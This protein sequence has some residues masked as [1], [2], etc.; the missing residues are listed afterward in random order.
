MNIA[1]V[2]HSAP[3]P[4]RK[5]GWSILALGL[6][7]GCGWYVH[8]FYGAEIAAWLRL[9][10]IGILVYACLVLLI[11]LGWIIFELIGGMRLQ[12]EQLRRQQE[13]TQAAQLERY[14]VEIEVSQAQVELV[15]AEREAH[16]TVVVADHD[17]AVFV[18]DAD[19]HA[20]WKPLHLIPSFRIN[21]VEATPSPLELG[22]WQ[23]WLPQRGSLPHPTDPLL[24]PAATW[25]ERIPLAELM[26]EPPS[27][28]RLLLGV[29]LDRSGQRQVV[30]GDMRQLIHVA[31]GGSSGWGKSML[32]RVLTYQLLLALEQPE[33]VLIDLEPNALAPFAHTPRLRFPLA[34]TETM[35]R[36]VLAALKEEML[37][38]IDLFARYE[39]DDLEEYNRVAAEPLKPI[40]CI[41]D[42]VNDL[43]EIEA[44]EN[45]AQIL[46]RRGRKAGI[47][48]IL[49]AQEWKVTAIDARIRRQ[50]STKIQFRAN[51]LAQAR[52]LVGRSGATLLTEDAPPGRAVAALPGKG[53]LSLQAPYLS[54][55]ELKQTLPTGEPL[56]PRVEL[57]AAPLSPE[58][59]RI[60]ELFLA[61]WAISAIAA[62][63]YGSK[64]GPQNE[65]VR[66]VLRRLGFEVD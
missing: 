22:V 7:A 56:Q 58:E 36:S 34:S 44:I 45:D 55:A 39:A 52:L 35:A 38:R 48:I 60:Q 25:P 13:Q 6:L 51:D 31:I 5:W 21:G 16:F 59:T 24:L 17:Q 12:R 32:L 33:L 64:G 26:T 47:W 10:L 4:T 53:I 14:K 37:R 41:A 18:R 65:R 20:V 23:N 9:I 1:E 50:L 19:P 8:L 30:T 63:V 11:Y 2:S 29:T 57:P 46:A 43:L 15:K 54:K 3:G 66:Q 61:G 40:V 49:A 27:L 62:E 28:Q 42:E